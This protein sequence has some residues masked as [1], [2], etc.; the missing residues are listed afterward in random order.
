MLST[1]ILRWWVG[2][3]Y[4]CVRRLQET[5]AAQQGT[6]ETGEWGRSTAR[7]F[8]KFG[9]G[10]VALCHVLYSW[11]WFKWDKRNGHCAKKWDKRNGH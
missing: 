3:R 9:I 11:F 5:G 1:A 6:V 8:V 4:G 10:G 7:I 2:G